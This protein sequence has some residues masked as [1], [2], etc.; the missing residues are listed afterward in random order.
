[1]SKRD[2]ITKEQFTELDE[3]QINQKNLGEQLKM[4]K[5]YS[6]L[7]SGP[8]GR[9]YPPQNEGAY[10]KLLNRTINRLVR[11]SIKADRTPRDGGEISAIEEYYR[12]L[13]T[14]AEIKKIREEEQKRKLAVERKVQE[15]IS[16]KKPLGKS[17]K[18]DVFKKT[19]VEN[20]EFESDSDEEEETK[21]PVDTIFQQNPE[22]K[23]LQEN[24][25]PAVDN[26][27]KEEAL[28]L[29]EG[30]RLSLEAQKEQQKFQEGKSVD[31]ED[32]LKANL[33]LLSSGGTPNL[34]FGQ[35]PQVNVQL[36]EPQTTISNPA[37]PETMRKSQA[38]ASQTLIDQKTEFAPPP[39]TSKT[40]K[41]KR[42]K[43]TVIVEAAK[44]PEKVEEVKETKSTPKEF[45]DWTTA[46]LGVGAAV[47]VFLGTRK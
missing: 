26:T 23:M 7:E 6:A 13:V 37:L 35:V 18:T 4:E 8:K 38:A 40:K 45:A 36:Q 28:L 34:N 31:V 39:E 10:A 27:N 33:N 12:R 15:K 5:E 42:K 17:S 30:I 11:E 9:S 25:P 43:T 3:E 1:M 14:Q 20:I 2:T 41:A 47:L 46:I 21:Q 16:G 29:Q 19:D 22:A 32:I 24:P 44:T